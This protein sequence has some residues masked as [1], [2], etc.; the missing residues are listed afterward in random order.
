MRLVNHVVPALDVSRMERAIAERIARNGLLA[1]RAI[2]RTA[3]Q[4]IGRTLAEGL[5]LENAAKFDVLAS[6]DSLKGRALSWRSDFLSIRAAE[7]LRQ[8]C[9]VA[10]ADFDLMPFVESECEVSAE[11]RIN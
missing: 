11:K 5:E 9:S 1:V 4:S 7:L 6:R 10:L 3:T 8:C 2:K